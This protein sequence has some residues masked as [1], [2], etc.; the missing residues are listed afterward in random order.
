MQ[1]PS[2]VS[3]WSPRLQA[4]SGV[5][6]IIAVAV[7]V[8]VLLGWGIGNETLKRIVPG[9]VAMNPMTALCFLAVGSALWLRQREGESTPVWAQVLAWSVVAVGILKLWEIM[10]GPPLGIDQLLFRGRLDGKAAAGFANRMAP[11]TAFCFVVTGLAIALLDVHWKRFWP[12]QFLAMI[13]AA[14]A[15]LALVGYA[16]GTKSFYGVGSFIPM[17]LHTAIAFLLL[18]LGVL[19]ARP[20]RG[21]MRTIVSDSDGGQIARL[22]LPSA[23]GIPFALGWLC[24]LGAHQGWLN[25]DAGLSLFVVLNMATF[26]ALV[27]WNAGMIHRSDLARRAAP[28][29]WRCKN[30]MRRFSNATRKCKPTSIW[31]ARFSRRFCRSNTSVFRSF[32]SRC[33]AHCSFIIATNRPQRW[34]AILP[35]C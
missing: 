29:L 20:Q 15:L 19:H 6:C 21:V 26:A 30:R 1:E 3:P 16:Y 22:L 10:G 4:F 28:R 27:W 11:N 34:A 32:R 14:A 35:M 9:L 7:G 2:V 8:L 31:R 12:A 5:T 24:T 17:A 33:R 23:I 25:V 18:L 13:G